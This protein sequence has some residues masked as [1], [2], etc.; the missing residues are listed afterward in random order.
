M[1][2]SFRFVGFVENKPGPDIDCM[3]GSMSFEDAINMAMDQFSRGFQNAMHSSMVDDNDVLIDRDY[4]AAR[5]AERDE[6]RAK[7]QAE[8]KAR[9]PKTNAEVYGMLGA[10]SEKRTREK[11]SAMRKAQE[12]GVE[13]P[14]SPSFGM[15]PRLKT[16]LKSWRVWP[17][18]RIRSAT[19][20][21]P[22]LMLAVPP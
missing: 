12:E 19:L 8:A 2:L 22:A 13:M 3:N 15:F 9:A 11:I 7:K 1:Y 17:S 18:P 16:P 14:H 4:L 6:L 5:R 21:I 10:Q 20:P